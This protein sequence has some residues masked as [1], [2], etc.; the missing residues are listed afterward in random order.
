MTPEE[1]RRHGHELIDWVADYRSSLEARPV[2]AVS[3]PGD[4]KAAFDKLVDQKRL[5]IVKAG[6][7]KKGEEDNKKDEK[8]KEEKKSDK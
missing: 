3:Q 1:F 2:M 7:V 5:V 4:V 8:K 6:D